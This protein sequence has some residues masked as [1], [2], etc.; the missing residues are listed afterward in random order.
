MHKQKSSKHR[1]KHGS[2]GGGGWSDWIWSP[3]YGKYYMYRVKSNGEWDYIWQESQVSQP[4]DQTIPREQPEVDAVSES[5]E[6]L[7]TSPS[8]TESSY[9]S[10][11]AVESSDPSYTYPPSGSHGTSSRSRK[12]KGVAYEGEP[13]DGDQPD[14][15]PEEPAPAPPPLDPFW[16]AQHA[17]RQYGQ[18]VSE[19]DRELDP[20]QATQEGLYHEHE[21]YVPAHDKT[22]SDYSQDSGYVTADMGESYDPGLATAMAASHNQMYGTASPGESST[23]PPYGPY[24]E[25]EEEE[26]A[27]TPKAQKSSFDISGT[28]G[29]AED[30]DPRYIVEPSH[31]FRPGSIFK[32]L[33]SEPSGTTV[34]GTPTISEKFQTRDKF[35]GP[36]FVGFRRFVVIA[37]DDGHCACVPI[38][39]YQGK[40]CNK[41][42]VKAHKHGIIYAQGSKPR[43]VSNE[44]KLGFAPIRAK[45][46]IEG[47]KLAK[48]SRINYSKLVTVE[49]NVKVFFIGFIG[50]DEIGDAVDAVNKCWEQKVHAKRRHNK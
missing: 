45:I 32:V 5:F 40:A 4:Q 38:L 37:N 12:G 15:Q 11:H 49:H 1:S 29:D 41:K 48:E 22:P 24:T 6:A 39:T 44:P 17:S 42:G 8:A 14:T 18:A 23:D 2:G 27:V 43:T 28:F 35:G 21:D 9:Y 13:Q 7:S 3:Q 50:Q 33:W 19:Q 26:G 34:G 20:P 31:K 25:Y 36:I 47:E 30:L 16:G 46:T 10:T